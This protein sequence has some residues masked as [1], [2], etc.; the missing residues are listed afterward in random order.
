MQ[1]IDDLVRENGELQQLNEREKQMLREQLMRKEAELTRAE[2][3]I[4]RKQQQMTQLVH[5]MCNICRDHPFPHA[6]HGCVCVYVCVYV[7]WV[8]MR[9]RG[10]L[11]RKKKMSADCWR[12]FQACGCPG[13]RAGLA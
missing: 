3:T 10:K 5:I 2:E 9:K 7:V 13:V 4:R 11:G 12:L 6:H 1:L 8:K